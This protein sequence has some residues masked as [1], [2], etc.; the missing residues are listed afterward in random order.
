MLTTTDGEWRTMQREGKK[1]KERKE[2]ELKI[3]SG[4]L[5]F[6]GEMR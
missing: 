2:R 5:P 4:T 1:E 6:S 3:D